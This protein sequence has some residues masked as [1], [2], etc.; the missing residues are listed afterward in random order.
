MQAGE[1]AGGQIILYTVTI[2]EAWAAFQAAVA[3]QPMILLG[4]F[5]PPLENL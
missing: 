3:L 4:L 5:V 1:I 2:S